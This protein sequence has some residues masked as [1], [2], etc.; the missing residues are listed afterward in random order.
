VLVTTALLDPPLR[1]K[2]S[3]LGDISALLDLPLLL[4]APQARSL[5]V[6]EN[7]LALLALLASTAMLLNLASTVPELPSS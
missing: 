1:L 4:L 2:S 5:W 3:A 7:F 6:T